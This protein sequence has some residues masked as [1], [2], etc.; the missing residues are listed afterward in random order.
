MS[1]TESSRLVIKFD[2]AEVADIFKGVW[3]QSLP[4]MAITINEAVNR[5][6]VL[7]DLHIEQT[8]QNEFTFRH[9]S[10][11]KGVVYT[12]SDDS[13]GVKLI[14]W[15][16]IP[17]FSKYLVPTPQGFALMLKNGNVDQK[18]EIF[19]GNLGDLREHIDSYEERVVEAKKQALE[20][21]KKAKESEGKDDKTVETGEA[22]AQAKEA[23]E[24][25]TDD[26]PPPGK[27]TMAVNT[28]NDGESASE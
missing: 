7:C 5:Q 21:E 13:I 23:L 18:L 20:A 15:E 19:Q 9:K 17:M 4:Q 6:G 27:A 3:M 16:D 25:Q 10:G 26:A 24:T 22:L 2:K 1:K 11:N 8:K 14:E 12:L 28:D